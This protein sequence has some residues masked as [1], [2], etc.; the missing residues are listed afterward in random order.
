MPKQ[1]PVVLKR[2]SPATSLTALH[3]LGDRPPAAAIALPRS[4]DLIAAI[5]VLEFFWPHVFVDSGRSKFFPAKFFGLE[6]IFVVCVPLHVRDV[7][8]FVGYSDQVHMIK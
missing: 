8:H 7:F 1:L 2:A 3:A 5:A 6:I 4:S